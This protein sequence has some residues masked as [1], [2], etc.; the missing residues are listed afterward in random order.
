MGMKHVS[1]FKAA[2]AFLV[3]TVLPF[4][5]AG[6]V[7]LRDYKR[8]LLSSFAFLL[9]VSGANAFPTIAGGPVEVNLFGLCF[10]LMWY[11][12]GLHCLFLGVRRAGEEQ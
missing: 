4:T 2:F 1:V 9:L 7:I 10:F 5:G 12:S 8:G 6:Y 3:Q 11:L